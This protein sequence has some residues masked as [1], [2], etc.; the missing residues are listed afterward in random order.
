MFERITSPMWVFFCSFLFLSS[1]WQKAVTLQTCDWP[2]AVMVQEQHQHGRSLQDVVHIYTLLHWK[3]CKDL[4]T[5]IP[6]PLGVTAGQHCGAEFRFG[7]IC[8]YACAACLCTSRSLIRWHCLPP[9]PSYLSK[10]TTL[11]GASP[12]LLLPWTLQKWAGS[13]C[14]FSQF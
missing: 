12:S 3:W 10:S 7:S 8:L 2:V 5:V 6:T 4:Y 9:G 11:A 1:L 13:P 14:A